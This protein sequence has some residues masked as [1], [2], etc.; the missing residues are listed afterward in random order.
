MTPGLHYQPKLYC[1]LIE[2][3][4]NPSQAVIGNSECILETFPAWVLQYLFQKEKQQTF[5]TLIVYYLHR[6]CTKHTY[7]IY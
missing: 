3:E 1:E 4:K 7:L 5:E 2:E 6:Q